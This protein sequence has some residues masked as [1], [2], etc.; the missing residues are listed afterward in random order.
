MTPGWTSYR[1]HLLYQTY[2]VT[3]YLQKGINGA[4]AMLAPGWYKGVMGLTKAR[5]NYGDQTAFTMELLIRYTDGTTESVYTD[6]SWK[7]CDSP[8]ICRNL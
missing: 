7:G 6:P 5:N 3:E 8:V 4:G 2:D 1:R